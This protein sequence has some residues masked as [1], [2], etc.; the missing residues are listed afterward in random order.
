MPYAGR[1]VCGVAFLARCTGAEMVSV[2]A[3]TD[4]AV[5]AAVLPTPLQAPKDPVVGAFVAHYP[6]TNFGVAYNELGCSWEPGTAA[7]R[8]SPAEQC[9]STTTRR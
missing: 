9:R 7:S 6:Q 2:V 1:A 3:R 5:A 4:P 8:G